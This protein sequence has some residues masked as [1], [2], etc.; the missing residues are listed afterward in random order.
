MTV[1]SSIG[2]RP[3]HFLP[4]GSNTVAASN[5]HRI[6]PSCQSIHEIHKTK[7][8]S[9]K[10][11]PQNKASGASE[12]TRFFCTR[13][14]SAAGAAGELKQHRKE[15]NMANRN[16][17]PGIGESV[18]SEV[19]HNPQPSRAHTRTRVVCHTG[20]LIIFNSHIL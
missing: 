2:G 20:I 5:A 18:D 10:Q 6:H 17:N 4:Y 7:E 14:S 9:I 16:T 1:L 11:Q 13:I 3:N 19:M 8:K 15:P 12:T